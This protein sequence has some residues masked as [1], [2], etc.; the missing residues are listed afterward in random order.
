M[1]WKFEKSRKKRFTHITTDGPNNKSKII[2]SHPHFYHTLI[3]SNKSRNPHVFSRDRPYPGYIIV[4]KYGLKRHIHSQMFAG[5]HIYPCTTD[6]VLIRLS[7]PGNFKRLKIRFLSIKRLY[8][9]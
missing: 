7:A 6:I 1:D 4:G 8:L 9:V 2:T 3:N 5:R